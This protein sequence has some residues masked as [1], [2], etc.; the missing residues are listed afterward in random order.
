[1]HHH[2][3]LHN[4]LKLE[5]IMLTRDGHVKLI[6]F[7]LARTFHGFAEEATPTGSLLYM[8]PELLQYI[9]GGT[10]RDWWAVGVIAHEV[11]TG[12][13]PWSSLTD[14]WIIRDEIIAPSPVVSPSHLPEP[15][16]RFIE[17]L[18]HKNYRLRLGSAS[19]TDVLSAPFFAGIDW[20]ATV[21]GVSLPAFVPTPMKPAHRSCVLAEDQRVALNEYLMHT[22]KHPQSTE[23]DVCWPL[24]MDTVEHEPPLAP[25]RFGLASDPKQRMTSFSSS[26]LKEEEN[27]QKTATSI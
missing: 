12:R 3:F 6:D 9:I 14:K 18:L 21:T 17:Q 8:P 15:A 10:F 7:G 1:M 19:S 24:A 27:T 22:R 11:L 26:H 13:S 5:N 25:Q 20:A 16:Q 4:D 23:G 2:H